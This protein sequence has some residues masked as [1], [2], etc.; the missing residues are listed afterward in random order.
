[1]MKGE[2]GYHLCSQNVDEGMIAGYSLP[3]SAYGGRLAPIQSASKQGGSMQTACYLLWCEGGAL[4][5]GITEEF[6][7]RME[8][9]F[10]GGGSVYTQWYTPI[11]VLGV[12]WF[13]V[14]GRAE[15]MEAVVTAGLRER[16]LKVA[17]GCYT[18]PT[19]SGRGKHW[20]AQDIAI[21]QLMKAIGRKLVINGVPKNDAVDARRVR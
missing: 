12:A 8:S 19:A 10:N 5:V 6:E 4:Y 14:R 20:L 18:K 3:T 16:W 15:W 21:R 1:M 7:A 2:S 9:H 11:K 17:G 13:P